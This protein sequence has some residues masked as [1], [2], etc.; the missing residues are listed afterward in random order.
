MHDGHPFLTCRLRRPFH[1]V[2]SYNSF[3]T[4]RRLSMVGISRGK[5]CDMCKERRRKVIYTHAGPRNN[6][7]LTT[8]QCDGRLP[9]CSLCTRLKCACV[10]PGKRYLFV[11]SRHDLPVG[12][13][14]SAE[15]EASGSS[16]EDDQTGQEPVSRPRAR[17]Y[18]SG[19]VPRSLTASPPHDL[20]Q[21]LAWVL[22]ESNNYG[23]N[24]ATTWG[25]YLLEI[26]KHIGECSALDAAV[27]VVLSGYSSF[28]TGR[29]CTNVTVAREYSSALLQLRE[30]VNNFTGRSLPLIIAAIMLLA[31]YEV[32][33]RRT[34]AIRD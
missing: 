19:A 8:D 34:I 21:K 5:R 28:R 7:R 12:H 6:C 14:N 16:T 30:D 2:A 22:S 31:L 11:G 4:R 10:R 29:H 3:D 15:P 20:A 25:D 27:K 13:A 17:S 23:Y 26:P 1:H 9:T 32:C 18:Y 24:M 33:Q